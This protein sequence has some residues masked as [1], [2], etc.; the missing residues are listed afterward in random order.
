[1][2]RRSWPLARST[3]VKKIDGP[4]LILEFD[5]IGS[6]LM[7]STGALKEFEIAGADKIYVPAVAKIIGKTV[8]VFS[9]SVPNPKFSRYAW[10]DVSNASL[11]NREG[12]P[13][14]SFTTE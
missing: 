7:S 8:E 1:M 2:E 3:G 5:F 6:G 12:L 13:A 10:R 11:F 9:A 14:S 4:K